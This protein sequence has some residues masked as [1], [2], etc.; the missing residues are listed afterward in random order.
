MKENYLKV[1]L[2]LLVVVVVIQGYFLYDVNSTI[3][4]NQVS[5]KASDSLAQP[6]MVPFVSFFDRSEDPFM[7]ME[8]IRREMESRFM[9]IEDFFQT[10]PSLNKMRS[11]LYRTPI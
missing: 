4:E 2:L 5:V 9:N 3:K 10:V 7:E 1:V 8:R 11:K 6:I